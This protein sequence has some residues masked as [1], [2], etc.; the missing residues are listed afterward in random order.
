MAP[1]FHSQARSSTNTNYY[2]HTEQLKTEATLL[3]SAHTILAFILY[4]SVLGFKKS[5]KRSKHFPSNTCVQTDKRVQIKT[6]DLLSERPSRL[7]TWGGGIVTPPFLFTLFSGSQNRK[8]GPLRL[9]VVMETPESVSSRC[10]VPEMR[11]R[12]P[13]ADS[14]CVTAST[15]TR[16]DPTFTR[17]LAWKHGDTF[18]FVFSLHF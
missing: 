18:D 3:A 11:A 10:E 2:Y 12:G 13:S 7:I 1:W 5:P 8:L 14:S 16:R 17:R 4:V 9:L 15:H 6:F